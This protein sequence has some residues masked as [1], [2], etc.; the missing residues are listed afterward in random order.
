MTE[1]TPNETPEAPPEGAFDEAN[2]EA[3]LDADSAEA[4]DSLAEAE[5]KAAEHLADLQR[6]Q[7]EYV[8]YRKRVERDKGAVVDLAVA[9]VVE[10][11][12]PVLDDIAAARNHGEL[13]GPF[14][15][16][17]DK[18]EASLERLGLVTYGIVGEPFDPSVHE[19]LASITEA[20]LENP[21]IREVSQAGH[22]I[23][24]RILRPARVVV[25][26]PE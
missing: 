7:A 12:V 24:D 21:I 13:E 9:R 19:A 8:N 4:G 11:L 1:P 23:G 26:Q 15:A 2:L 16:I 14:A 18:L 25:A 22:R 10:A 6:L 20:G 17:A 5:S 3:T